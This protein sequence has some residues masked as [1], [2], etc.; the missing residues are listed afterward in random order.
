MIGLSASIAH[1]AARQVAGVSGQLGSV[2]RWPVPWRS[3][4]PWF[5]AGLLAGGLLFGSLMPAAAPPR[6]LGW[7]IVAGVLVGY[8]T[9]LGSGCTSGHGV[10]GLSRLSL[11]SLIATLTFMLTAAAVVFVTRH[12]LASAGVP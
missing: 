7:L 5:V 3:F 12:V 6:A 8:G 10:C 9:R 1:G 11:R 4:G 2:L